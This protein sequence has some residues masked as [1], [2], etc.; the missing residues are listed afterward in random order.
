MFPQDLTPCSEQ[1]QDV[2]RRA[3]E[4]S[5]G[6]R[7]DPLSASEFVE[8]VDVGG[9]ELGLEGREQLRHGDLQRL[10]LVPIHL[11]KEHGDIGAEGAVGAADGGSGV[12]GDDEAAH[13]RGEL[14]EIASRVVLQDEGEAAGVAE[15][16]DGRRHEGD[17]IGV[18]GAGRDLLRLADDGAQL[19]G[20]VRA[21][22]VFDSLK[23]DAVHI[24]M[25]TLS[26]QTVK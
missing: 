24:C 16:G 8:V 11:Q 26:L 21:D 9:A 6:L 5:L 17:D 19:Q 7:H 23:R 1:A 10:H 22:K 25:C 12:G 13:R 3:A 20:R 14:L 18:R 4:V 15:P 2:A